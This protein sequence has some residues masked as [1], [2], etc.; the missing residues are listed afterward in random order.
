M[1]F[2]R[3]LMALTIAVF[4]GA[5]F[6]QASI[7]TV[8]SSGPFELRAAAVDPKGV[9]SWPVLSGD[10]IATLSH[11]A[12]VKF[13]DGSR[14]VLAA[15]SRA[16]IEQGN[17]GPVFCL[18]DGAVAF[19]PAKTTRVT[20]SKNTTPEAITCEGQLPAAG[21]S[22]EVVKVASAGR[23]AP[24]AAA[25]TKTPIIITTVAAGTAA[26]SVG[27]WAATKGEDTPTPKPISSR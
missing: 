24:T 2:K 15:K 12:T 9:P 14:V 18:F 7:A 6:G 17:Q 3:A 27:V 21:R 16:R 22:G 5:A 1:Q 26:T 4:T 13:R 8:T 20:V 23:N 10:N 19:T 11:S 25:F